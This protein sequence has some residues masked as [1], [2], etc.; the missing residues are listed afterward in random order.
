MVIPPECGYVAFIVKVYAEV[1][2][3]WDDAGTFHTLQHIHAGGLVIDADEV[4]IGPSI[5]W[6]ITHA[7][8]VLF[9]GILEHEVLLFHNPSF[10]FCD[11]TRNVGDG[12]FF[13]LDVVSKIVNTVFLFL[14]HENNIPCVVRRLPDN[15]ASY[16]IN[17]VMSQH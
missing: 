4:E 14:I 10:F 1:I 9:N 2:A 13:T 12:L 3:E 17:T 6:V 5:V 11:G 15:F 16:V 8:A 7:V